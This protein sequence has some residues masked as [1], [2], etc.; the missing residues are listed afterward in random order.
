[1]IERTHTHPTTRSARL[2]KGQNVY[3]AFGSDLG[4]TVQSVHESSDEE[5]IHLARATSTLGKDIFVKKCQ[6]DGSFEKGCQLKSVPAL[7][8]TLVD[9]I[10]YGPRIDMQ[11]STMSKSQAGL[12]ITQLIQFKSFI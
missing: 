3:L 5:A 10:L 11:S 12:M 8:F 6:F 4:A 9:M 7:L 2:Q 1:M